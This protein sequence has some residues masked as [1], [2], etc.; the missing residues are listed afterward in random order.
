MEANLLGSVQAVAVAVALELARPQSH[1]AAHL[2]QQLLAVVVVVA[3]GI[4]LELVARDQHLRLMGCLLLVVALEALTLLGLA[5][6]DLVVALDV[7]TMD[8]LRVQLAPPGKVTQVEILADTLMAVVLLAAAVAVGQVQS[9][10]CAVEIAVETVDPVIRLTL[11]WL[12]Q[13]EQ[14]L[15]VAML[16]AAVVAVMT[17]LELDLTVALMVMDRL[18]G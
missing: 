4:F 17:A 15:A 6:V 9:V 18:Q 12:A 8:L 1:L 13:L 2:L 11:P 14:A 3:L 7:I 16:A 5:V 10:Q